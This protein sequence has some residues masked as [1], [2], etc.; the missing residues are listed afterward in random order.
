MNRNGWQKA[1]CR[2]VAPCAAKKFHSATLAAWITSGRSTASTRGRSWQNWSTT[3]AQQ[4]PLPHLKNLRA[5][6]KWILWLTQTLLTTTSIKM[7]TLASLSWGTW[8]VDQAINHHWET[9]GL[10]RVAVTN[11]QSK[12]K[13]HHLW[14]WLTC[15]KTKIP[16]TSVWI[17]AQ[18]SNL[19]RSCRLLPK[20]SEE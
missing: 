3:K 6:P 16:L 15:Q 10:W 11:K 17:C 14:K 4:W 13:S 20:T 12:S 9:C 5:P 19:R 1:P 2:K 7:L 18:S 8:N